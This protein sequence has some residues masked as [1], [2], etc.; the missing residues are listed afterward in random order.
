MSSPFSHRITLSATLI[1][2]GLLSLGGVVLYPSVASAAGAVY[3]VGG[4]VTSGFADR[5]A[6]GAHG[7]LD[8]ASGCTPG[9][10]VLAAAGGKV[11]WAGPRG[12]F[13]RLVRI[14]HDDGFETLYAHLDRV[15]VAVG[16]TV[17]RGHPIGLEG[18][19]GRAS[20]HHVHF[21]V[22]RYGARCWLP[23]RAGDRV[24]AGRPIGTAVRLASPEDARAAR[25]L[26]IGGVGSG[27]DGFSVTAGALNVRSG[28]GTG[29]RT[30]GSLR[31]ADLVVSVEERGAWRRIA[32]RG[33]TAWVHGGYLASARTAAVEV[34]ASVLN[35]RTGPSTSNGRVGSIRRGQVYPVLARSGVW[36][37]IP[38]GS[39]S[40][41]WCHG[42]YTRAAS[43]DAAPAPTPR[44]T[45]TPTPT[46]TGSGWQ[47]IHAGLT[48]DGVPIP[49]AGIRNGTLRSVFG[50]SVEPYGRSITHRGRSFAAGTVSWFGGPSD[51]GVS[52]T[53]TG[54]ITGERLRSLHRQSQPS[55]SELARNPEDYYY[56]A[57]R[58]D[59]GPRGRTWWRKARLLVVSPKN[60]VAIVVRPV[61]WGPNTRTR[62]VIDLGRQCLRDLGISTDGEAYVSFA[63][64]G[65]PLGRV[66]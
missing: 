37:A 22:R 54:A 12:G 50:I 60:G 29:Y 45:P 7:A 28:P 34:T 52:S 40:R 20:G 1:A 27:L 43:T 21:E 14:A 6:D 17:A 15:D 33:Q 13:G 26:G 57:M 42:G 9:A 59:Y 11:T 23:G 38:W 25:A 65:T 16:Q 61:D 32:H 19:T 46:P 63:R 4:T 8:I 31:R 58:F 64:P 41:R 39:G 36:V 62:R 56:A 2:A 47:A 55:S 30:V 44:P 35:V 24:R 49:R 66:R 18:A 3:P 10:K 53:E 48:Q 5:R 51:R